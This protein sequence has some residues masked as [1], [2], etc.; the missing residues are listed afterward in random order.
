MFANHET[1]ETK[2]CWSPKHERKAIFSKFLFKIIQMRMQL[3]SP[4]DRFFRG[5][6]AVRCYHPVSVPRVAVAW[7]SRRRL[8]SATLPAATRSCAPT[9]RGEESPH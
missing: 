1:I 9:G 7:R 5:K 4:P 2:P 6:P 8:R 3:L